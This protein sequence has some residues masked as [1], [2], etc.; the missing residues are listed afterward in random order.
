MTMLSG[1]TDI[2]IIVY[3]LN[4]TVYFPSQG[5][6]PQDSWDNTSGYYLKTAHGEKWEIC[7]N[8]PINGTIPLKLGWNLIPVLSTYPVTCAELFDPITQVMI[9]KEAVGTNLYWK[10][11][12]IN[13]LE[14]LLPGKAYLVYSTDSA[15][16]TFDQSSVIPTEG[17]ITYYPFNGNANDESG[18]G[19]NG[20]VYGAS[21]STDRFGNNN[22]AYNFDGSND[23]VSNIIS[24]NSTDSLTICLWYNSPIPMNI[25]STHFEMWEAGNEQNQIHLNFS[26]N[27]SS[28]YLYTW[29]TGIG[30]ADDS[31]GPRSFNEWH[32]VAIIKAGTTETV[33]IDNSPD[34]GQFSGV[35]NAFNF[36][37]LEIG[38]EYT[39]VGSL[40][41]TYFNGKIDD[42]RIYNRALNESEINSIYHEGGWDK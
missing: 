17:L 39:T 10:T 6:I 14:F 8:E 7:G 19:N 42:I 3:N 40:Y 24:M 30:Q 37:K 33:Y 25:S 21:L 9:V 15:S 35:N 11:W 4:N 32:F 5:I 13:T 34:F 41:S 2:L 12:N 20:T 1:L 28:A 27:S 38:R 31:F 29:I 18:N 23:Y 26:Y 36:D 22:K 16:F